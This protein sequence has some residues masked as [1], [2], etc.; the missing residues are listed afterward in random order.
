[1]IVTRLSPHTWHDMRQLSTCGKLRPLPWTCHFGKSTLVGALV[2]SGLLVRATCREAHVSVAV[3]GCDSRYTVRYDRESCTSADLLSR[4]LPVRVL[5]ARDIHWRGLSV[6][7]EARL[8]SAIFGVMHLGSHLL[9]GQSET[10][11]GL[12]FRCFLRRSM[13]SHLVFCCHN[14][15]RP[16]RW[17]RK[18][19]ADQLMHLSDISRSTGL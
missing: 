17:A 3:L 11:S 15:Q 19:T 14:F 8:Q 7:P 1:V 2:L 5:L 13:L 9:G 6:L 4:R 12:A 18:Y 10:D 16:H